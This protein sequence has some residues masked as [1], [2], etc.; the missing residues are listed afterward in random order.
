MQSNVQIKVHIHLLS[1]TDR[2]RK[3]EGGDDQNHSERGRRFHEKVV[4]S[5]AWYDLSEYHARKA[6]SIVADIDS[7]LH[8][9]EAF[10]ENLDG[11]VS[12]AAK[13]HLAVG[14]AH[15]SHFQRHQ[16]T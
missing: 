8:L 15:L 11:T 3:V 2:M 9:A 14:I 7:L 16:G 1:M 12:T 5:L 6:D 10:R 4:L 13:L